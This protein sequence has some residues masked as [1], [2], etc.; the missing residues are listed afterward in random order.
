MQNIGPTAS[1]MFRRKHGDSNLCPQCDQPEDYLHI[2]RCHG[3]GTQNLFDRDLKDIHEWMEKLSTTSFRQAINLLICAARENTVPDFDEITE[4]DIKAAAEKQWNLGPQ[5][6][7]WGIWVKDWVPIQATTLKGTR[8]CPRVWISKLVNEIW[9]ITEDMWKL[10]NEAEH[11]DGQ[12]RVN[13]ERNEKINDEIDIIYDK[14]PTN[15]RIMPQDDMQFFSKKK[16]FRKQRRLK[17][18]IRWVTKANRIIKG[19]EHIVSTNPSA[20]LVMHN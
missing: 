5:L 4:E 3:P 11:K 7:L 17:E 18:E 20:A 9:K 13:K 12:S 6:L 10:R 1:N 14:L 2:L 8:K 15:L 19:Y 16:E